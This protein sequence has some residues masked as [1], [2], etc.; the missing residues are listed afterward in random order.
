MPEYDSQTIHELERLLTVSPFDQQL[1]LRLATA[2]YAQAC[3]ACSVTRD[4][5]LVMTTQAQR[6]TC[7][8]AAWR[9]LEL[10][11]ADPALVQAATE[12]QREVREGDDWI[13][14]PRGTGTLLTAVVVLAGLALVSIM[15][16]ADDFVLAGVAAALS[17]ALLA[18]VVLR[19]RRQSWRIRAEQ[20]QTSIWEHGI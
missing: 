15:V 7:G 10:Q 2:L 14:H 17:S 4:G 5:K 20:A 8:R 11:V 19:F 12:L 18:F 13:W 6:D 9:V 16:R 3:A 1:R